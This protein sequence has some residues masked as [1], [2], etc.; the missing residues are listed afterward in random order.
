[1]RARSPEYLINEAAR[2]LAEIP[3]ATWDGHELPVPID[4][5]TEDHFGLLIQE[6]VDIA[7]AFPEQAPAGGAPASGAL[8]PERAEIW[9][10]ATEVSRSP[11]RRRDAV[12]HE[13]GHWILHRGPETLLCAT[14]T[15]EPAATVTRPEG[16][17]PRS[18]P[19]DP[20]P[21]A[22]QIEWEANLFGGALLLPPWLVREVWERSP[23]LE[24]LSEAFDCTLPALDGG[25]QEHYGFVAGDG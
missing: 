6:S 5:I 24:A 15:I 22:P 9:V 4:A 2:L 8:I 1:M 19:W 14:S 7:A 16:A 10:D 23:S 21:A 18:W 17:G 13:L 11:R 25:W 3:S 20:R 12:A